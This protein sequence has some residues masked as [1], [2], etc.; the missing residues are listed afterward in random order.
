MAAGGAFQPSRRAGTR[1][2]VAT[3]RR[4]Q[5]ECNI[6]VVS[7]ASPMLRAQRQAPD[8]VR[9]RRNVG[10]LHLINARALVDTDIAAARTRACG[11]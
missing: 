4:D 10:Y 11:G 9:N 1:Q 2:S 6:E 3:A 7:E 5:T 8:R